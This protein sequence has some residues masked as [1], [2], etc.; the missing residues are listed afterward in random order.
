MGKPTMTRRRFLRD[1]GVSAAAVPLL[2]G[3]DSLYAKAA[4]PVVA[5]NRFIAMYTPNGVRYTDW[6]IP[7]AGA[8]IDISSGALLTSPTL[9]LSPLAPNA[10]KLLILD[11]LSW[12][13]ARQLYNGQ[14]GPSVDAPLV[15]PGGHQKGMGNLLTGAQLIGGAGTIGDAGLANG[16]SLDQVLAT[17]V[18]AGK[19]KFPSLQIGVNVD[20]NLTDRY[21]DKRMSYSGVRMPLPPVVDP[22][23]L[24]NQVFSGLSTT[25]MGMQATNIRL[26]MD[27]SVLDNVQQDFMRLQTKVSTADWQLLQQHMT[28]IRDI[29]QQLTAVFQV[30]C[31][32]PMAPAAPTGVT[33]TDP[34]A[35]HKWAMTLTNMPTVGSLLTDIMVQAI[36]CGLTNVVTFQ[37]ANSEDKIH[38]RI[39]KRRKCEI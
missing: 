20:E 16:I 1:L 4:V 10:S 34:I 9:L 26:L 21:V 6:R 13:G 3:L 7:M 17:Q 32:A 35:T 39:V 18:F 30:S 2:A 33:T 5:K 28:A 38:T 14:Q 11:R 8:D 25:P 12:I 24:Y 19:V 29:E 23:V 31:N 36:A 37:W 15:H 27:K 22:F